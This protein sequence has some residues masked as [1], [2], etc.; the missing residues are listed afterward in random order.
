MLTEH[1]NVVVDVGCRVGG[2][3]DAQYLRRAST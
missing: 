3:R 2:S 1:L